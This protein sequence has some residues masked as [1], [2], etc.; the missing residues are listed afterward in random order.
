MTANGAAFG[1]GQA[2][3]HLE[4]IEA[5]RPESSGGT[6]APFALHF[7]APS[8]VVV[9]QRIYTLEHAAL[10]AFELFIVPISR[11][12]RGSRYEAIFT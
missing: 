2:E 3:L 8:G 10:G 4:D 11:D 7:R 6:R 1:N 5:L 9:P 12:Q